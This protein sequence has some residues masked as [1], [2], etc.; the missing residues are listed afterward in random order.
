VRRGN[1]TDGIP[2]ELS[3]ER[4]TALAAGPRVR[5]ERIVSRG[6]SSP[7]GFWYDQDQHEYV[8]VVSGRARLEIEGYG[9]L[10]LGPCDW[11]DIPCHARHRVA[12]TDPAADTVW[13]AVFYSAVSD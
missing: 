13:L 12:W 7:A 4:F 2:R 11:V 3:A 5:I 10:E 8:L 6:Q 9:E 1:L